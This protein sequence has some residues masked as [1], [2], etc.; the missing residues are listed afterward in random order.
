MKNII[1][2]K[3]GDIPITILVIA[4]VVLCVMALF[5]FYAVKDKIKG[6]AYSAY[7]LQDVYNLAESIQYSGLGVLDRYK[8]DLQEYDIDYDSGTNEFSIKRTYYQED[9]GVSGNEELLKVTYEFGG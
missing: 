6:R 1:K 5:S 4:V 8:Q 7:F 2:N 9:L 3:R